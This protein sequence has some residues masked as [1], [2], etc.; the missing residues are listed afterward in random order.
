MKVVVDPWLTDADAGLIVPPAPAVA[1]TV[2]FW[3]SAVQLAVVPPFVPEQLQVHGPVPL[4]DVAFPA[5]QRFVVGIVVTV[6]PFDV[7]HAPLTG[8]GV[9]VAAIVQIP[10][11][12]PVVYVLPFKVPPQPVTLLML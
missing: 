1:V 11:I 3:I 10:V 5:L 8:F 9:N 4:T 6:N 2:Y 12:G 7:P